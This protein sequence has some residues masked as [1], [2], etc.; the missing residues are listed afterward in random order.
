MTK[1]FLFKLYLS[2]PTH[3]NE[4]IVAN[5]K[6]I[7]ADKCKDQYSLEIIYVTENPEPAMRVSVFSTPSLFK[8]LPPPPTIVIG[9]LTTKEKLLFAV[10]LV[11]YG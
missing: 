5:L 10:D 9:D 2:S 6:N 8:Q 3:S 4:R 7:L 1:E 11:I